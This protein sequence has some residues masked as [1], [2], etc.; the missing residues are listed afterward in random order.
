MSNSP[1]IR[2]Q[3]ILIW[4]PAFAIACSLRQSLLQAGNSGYDLFLRQLDVNSLGDLHAVHYAGLFAPEVWWFG[5]LLPLALAL[6]TARMRLR[7][8]LSA[9]TAASLLVSIVLFIE[10]KTFWQVGTFLPFSVLVSGLHEGAGAQYVK[11]YVYWTSFAK[12]GATIAVTVLLAAALGKPSTQRILRRYSSYRRLLAAGAAACGVGLAICQSNLPSTPYSRSLGMMALGT[13][14]QFDLADY[15]DASVPRELHEGSVTRIR[16][17]TALPP[18]DLDPR[19]TAKARDYNVLF[20]VLETMPQA[21]FESD[22]PRFGAFARLRNNALIS[23]HH[24]TTYPYTVR[25]VP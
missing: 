5:L 20:I 14:G 7:Y 9:W 19:F 11:Q 6:A 10:L 23:E 25:A 8:Y 17:A 16:I 24:Y 3:G 4:L 1:R 22:D 2:L 18:P 12:L 13:F 15:A 21:V